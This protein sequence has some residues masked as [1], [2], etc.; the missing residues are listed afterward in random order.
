[1]KKKRIIKEMTLQSTSKLFC[2]ADILMEVWTWDIFAVHGM[3]NE[4][5]KDTEGV[6]KS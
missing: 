1:M 4:S 6:E 3:R 5:C 2:L